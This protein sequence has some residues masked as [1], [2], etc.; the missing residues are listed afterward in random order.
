MWTV[1]L[2]LAVTRQAAHATVDQA[3]N[4]FH[5]D[6]DRAIREALGPSVL[7]DYPRPSQ[8]QS[9]FNSPDSEDAGS[10]RYEIWG[11]PV[12]TARV[13]AQTQHQAQARAVK[14]W[15]AAFA[16]LPGI[17]VDL[18]DP[19]GVYVEPYPY[20]PVELDVDTDALP[21]AFTPPPGHDGGRHITEARTMQRQA[22]QAWQ[23][24]V[25]QIRAALIDVL[26][27]AEVVCDAFAVHPQDGLPITYTY[28]FREPFIV[29]AGAGSYRVEWHETYLVCL[30]ATHSTRL[31]EHAVR[32]QLGVLADALP[33]I[34]TIRL[35]TAYLGEH[36]DHRLEPDRD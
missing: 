26:V 2:A 20:G 1:Q 19:D 15:R 9:T 31:A 35:T 27:N 11:H 13:P 6:L 14:R 28:T 33:G 34:A 17:E 3:L 32:L 29:A 16:G 8:A 7:I 25:R 4:A 18:G 5:D 10:T 23:Y 21:E 30:R 12:L 22:L 36:I 24:Q